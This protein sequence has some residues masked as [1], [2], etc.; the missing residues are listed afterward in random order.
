MRSILAVALAVAAGLGLSGCKAPQETVETSGKVGMTIRNYQV[1]WAR[2]GKLG[3]LRTYDVADA[4]RPGEKPVPI[5][6]V[7]DLDLK[8]DRGWVS[9]NGL[10]ERFE[11]PADRVKEA[12]RAPFER[13][14]LPA[15]TIENQIKRIL[16]VDPGTEIALRPAAAS[17]VSR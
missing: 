8:T 4:G 11:Y 17:D 14:A 16:G 9:D 2:G 15:D 1:I 12:Y 13:V 3:Y 6:Y 5:H 10:G 7:L